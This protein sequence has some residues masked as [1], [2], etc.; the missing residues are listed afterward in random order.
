MF[1]LGRTNLVIDYEENIYVVGYEYINGINGMLYTMVSITNIGMN[2]GFIIKFNKDGIR[3]WNDGFGSD[4]EDKINDVIVSNAG[5]I[6]VTGETKGNLNGNNNL[7]TSLNTFDVFLIKYS[8]TGE[9]EWSKQFG[10]DKNDYGNAITI[11]SENRILVAGQSEGRFD[12]KLDNSGTTDAF[13][14]KFNEKGEKIWSVL[15]NSLQNHISIA[16]SIAVDDKNDIYVTGPIKTVSSA[17]YQDYFL[18][19]II[20]LVKNIMKL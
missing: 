4:K 7:D 9:R 8:H 12:G 2:D 1:V 16:E 11:D 17:P 18:I 10:S 19:N 15:N 5:N 6:Y 13:V 3:L 14:I 20:L